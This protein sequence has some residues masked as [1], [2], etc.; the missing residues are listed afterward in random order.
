MELIKPL[1]IVVYDPPSRPTHTTNQWS[2]AHKHA[3]THVRTHIHT[4]TD[5]HASK[6]A[7]THSHTQGKYTLSLAYRTPTCTLSITHFLSLS[8]TH[9]H[10]QMHGC[11]TLPHTPAQVSVQ[12]LCVRPYMGSTPDFSP[13][14]PSLPAFSA[15][16]LS[17]NE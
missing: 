8:H 3:R 1:L 7:L 14:Y 11:I 17:T 10:A 5:T 4:Q 15:P 9:K 16:S 6:H 13:S 2:R 12:V